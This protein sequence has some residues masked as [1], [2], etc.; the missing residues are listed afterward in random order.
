ME[1]ADVLAG[2]DVGG[3]AVELVVSVTMMTVVVV[4]QNRGE[5]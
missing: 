5:E 3:S 1:G 4:K 2:G